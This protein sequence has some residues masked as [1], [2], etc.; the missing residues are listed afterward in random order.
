MLLTNQRNDVYDFLDYIIND[1][2]GNIGVCFM[3]YDLAI[4]KL[5]NSEPDAIF[6]Y[7]LF[8]K[9][10]NK[11]KKFLKKEGKPTCISSFPTILAVIH[12]M[13]PRNDITRTANF[14]ICLW[15]YLHH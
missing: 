5:L 6:M 12:S 15:L 11:N 2:T 9:T 14:C 10:F 7:N 4:N 13:R 8:A 3:D 1:K